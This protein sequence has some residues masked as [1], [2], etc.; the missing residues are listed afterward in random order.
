MIDRPLARAFVPGHVTG[1][2]TVHRT[3][4]PHTTGSRGAGFTL[5]DGV[6]VSV[7]AADETAVSID[8]NES[9]VEPV[10]RVLEALDVRAF[11]DVEA[12]LPVGT[13]FGLSGGMALGT[14]LAANEGFELGHTENE[15][16]RIAHVA[17]VEAGT[18]LGD[19]VAQA[20]GGIVLRLE[21]GAPPHGR[22]DGIPGRG[23]VEFLTFGELSTPDVLTA[24]PE[25]ITRAGTSALESLRENPTAARFVQTASDFSSEIGLETEAV[26]SIL[27]TVEDT[28]N[29]A[30]M[31][32][33][34]ETVFAFGRALS[35]AGFDP[36][37]SAIDPCG[38]RLLE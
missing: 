34:G 38:A 2:F 16:I 28:G 7:R 20:R 21:P 3:E 10:R 24:H 13:G 32:M 36:E 14:A 8:G 19:V 37:V 11:V 35:D 17:D 33:L 29:T 31:A 6:T 25:T 22:L 30:S 5:R 1:L 18:G 27:D 9:V 26:G 15:L 4:D 23:R 12:D